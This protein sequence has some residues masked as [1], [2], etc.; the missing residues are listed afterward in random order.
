VI[1]IRD[2]TPLQAGG[3]TP[4]MLVLEAAKIGARLALEEFQRS[5]K[6]RQ[7]RGSG[8]ESLGKVLRSTRENLG[9]TQQQLAS[10][11]GIHYTTIGKIE[12]GDRGMSLTTFCKLAFFLGS[13]FYEPIISNLGFPE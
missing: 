4:Q 2:L 5:R 1:G 6:E 13:D 7:D 3:V 12:T 11:T 8:D 9:L 10:S